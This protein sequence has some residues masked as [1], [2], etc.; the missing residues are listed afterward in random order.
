[1]IRAFARPRGCL[2]H[3]GSQRPYDQWIATLNGLYLL[4]VIQYSLR[5]LNP[6]FVAGKTLFHLLNEF[7][8][9]YAQSL[10]RGYAQTLLCI[11]TPLSTAKVY[12]WIYHN[13]PATRTLQLR[14]IL[15]EFNRPAAA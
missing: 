14:L 2:C 1:M 4:G 12:L 7:I 11:L 9:D 6:L 5:M 15:E 8:A 3:A 13:L 10:Y